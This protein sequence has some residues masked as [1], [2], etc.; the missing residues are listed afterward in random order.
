MLSLC[1]LRIARPLN[2]ETYYCKWFHGEASLLTRLHTLLRK[3]NNYC[4][5][6]STVHFLQTEDLRNEDYGVQT[7]ERN[8]HVEYSSL[9][10]SISN[11][12]IRFCEAFTITRS[13]TLP[14]S[15]SSDW[16]IRIWLNTEWRFA[17]TNTNAPF[18]AGKT[19]VVSLKSFIWEPTRLLIAA[20]ADFPNSNVSV[21]HSDWL[22]LV[23]FRIRT[24]FLWRLV[25]WSS[26]LLCAA[27]LF[28]Q[29]RTKK[30]MQRTAT[31][32]PPKDTPMMI[33]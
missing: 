25:V 1:L 7:H 3:Q 6:C 15:T 14:Q 13:I 33:A 28:L 4:F 31:I 30:M 11:S 10:V 17:K 32:S 16:L 22:Q 20:E 18:A 12:Y 8:A 23:L 9:S 27:F 24:C 2:Y 29:K 5:S 21:V 19:R 26:L